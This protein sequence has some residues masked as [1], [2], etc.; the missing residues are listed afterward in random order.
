MRDKNGDVYAWGQD[1]EGQLADN[2]TTN[3]ATLVLVPA[4]EDAVSIQSGGGTTYG[5]TCAAFP[6]GSAKCWGYN[7][8][9]YSLGDGTTYD[10]MTGVTPTG[11]G[12]NVATMGVGYGH[13]CGLFADAS[14][15]CWGYN[16][17]GQLGRGNTTTSKTPVAVE[18]SGIS[19]ISVGYEHTCARKGEEAYCWG[20]NTSGQV[21]DGTTSNVTS[22]ALVIESGVASIAAGYL[23]TCAVMTDGTAMCWGD[24][25]N[26]KLGNNSAGDVSVPTMVLDI[27]GA[28]ASL[29]NVAEVCA[30]GQHTC[31]R[32]NDGRVA[33]WG[34][35]ANGQLGTGNTTDSLVPKLVPGIVSA[36]KLVCGYV[37]TCVIDNGYVK[38]WGDNAYRQVGNA[39]TADA[40][41]PQI[42]KFL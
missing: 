21:G 19:Q 16:T 27:D 14:M 35:N 38:C 2:D 24:G 3:K 29:T 8:S 11:F 13:G 5:W 26:G 20:Y 17:Y 36:T 6:N 34:D 18:L 15:K 10:T 33:C 32:L 9:T 4:L 30:G 12:S 42:A 40:T 31:A 28:G 37:H 1:D 7:S 41:T 39:S 22:P 23:H 25:L